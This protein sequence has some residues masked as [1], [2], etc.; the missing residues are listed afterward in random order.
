MFLVHNVP[1]RNEPVWGKNA[2]LYPN[3]YC[4]GQMMF[5]RTL[6]HDVQQSRRLTPTVS[7]LLKS[8]DDTSVKDNSFERTRKIVYGFPFL[9]HLSVQNDDPISNIADK[10]TCVLHKMDEWLVTNENEER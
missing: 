6:I 4:I 2:V 5:L 9:M 7:F 1:R 3:L 10:K 8:F